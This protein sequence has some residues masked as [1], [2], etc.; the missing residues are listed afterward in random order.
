MIREP[1]LKKKI[2]AEEH[3]QWRGHEV[4]RIEG[5]TDAV[6]AFGVTLLI[7]SL[8]V[9]KTY[10]ELM[11]A[12]RGFPAFAACFAI[13]MWIWWEQYKFFRRYGVEDPSTIAL[14]LALLF[15]VLFYIYPLKFIFTAMFAGALGP[16]EGE[17]AEATRTL[18]LVFALGF[19]AVF[20]LLGAMYLNVLR[21]RKRL[22]LNEMELF[23]TRSAVV[24]YLLLIGIGVL[25]LVLSRFRGFLFSLAGPVYFLIGVVETVFNTIVGRRRNLLSK[26]LLAARKAHP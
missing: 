5:L 1:L 24:E 16:Q 9:P 13:L 7:V 23:E 17:P 20:V 10:E 6:F 14:N 19:M 22:E 3:F 21:L 2:G 4:S 11:T 8:E 26:R 18:L 25:S 12:I 15:V